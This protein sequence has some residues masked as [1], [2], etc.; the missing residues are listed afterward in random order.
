MPIYEYDCEECG[1]RFEFLV[2]RAD[3][4]PACPSCGA[5][6]L[7]KRF[8]VFAPSGGARGPAPAPA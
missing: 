2:Q 8:S 4:Q 5:T 1:H 7:K 3:E 6:R